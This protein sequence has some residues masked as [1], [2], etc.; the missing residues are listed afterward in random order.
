MKNRFRVISEPNYFDAFSVGNIKSVVRF[1]N[2]SIYNTTTYPTLYS[3][4]TSTCRYV[5]REVQI[6]FFVLNIIFITYTSETSTYVN[7][8]GNPLLTCFLT[9]LDRGQATY[10]DI[11]LLFIFY[12]Q[13]VLSL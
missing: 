11:T 3:H 12:L 2:T 9:T 6:C 1:E 13:L 7:Y 8:E 5:S 4:F 10:C